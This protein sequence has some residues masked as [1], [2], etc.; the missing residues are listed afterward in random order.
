MPNPPTPR[1]M[2]VQELGT[3]IGLS[4]ARIYQLI[5]QGRFPAPDPGEHSSR[6]FFSAESMKT[7]LR[8]KEE[9]IALDGK[10]IV[11]N[12]KV[13]PRKKTEARPES[14]SSSLSIQEYLEGLGME[15]PAARL[16]TVLKE[17]YPNGWQRF[18]KEEVVQKAFQR[19]QEEDQ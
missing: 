4:R 5:R 3:L 12:R 14:Q 15:I 16:N 1:P 13:H 6:T 8:I 11:F 9:G 7:I 2:T 19:L 10:A 17:L 18:P